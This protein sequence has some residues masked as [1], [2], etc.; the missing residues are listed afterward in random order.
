MIL[1]AVMCVWN[2]E[3]IIESTVRHCFAQGCSQV[4]IIDNASTD[5]TVE[6]AVNAGA[7]LA[8][9][10]KTKY[11]DEDKKVAH[12]N[13]TVEY[14]NSITSD[15][16][17]WWLYLDADEF[18]NFDSKFTI[19]EVLKNLDSSVRA[20]HGAMFDHKPTH[21]PYYVSGY[22]P[23]DFQP[24]CTKSSVGKIPL[25]RYDRG[26]PHLFSM[27]GA[28]NFITQ[29]DN[30]LVANDFIQ[31]H[32]F[33]YRNPEATLK[34]STKLVHRN[35]DGSSRIDWHDNF[36]KEVH[37]AANSK[38]ALSQYMSRHNNLK[39][40]YTANKH[41]IL[42]QNSLI[43][44]YKY[45][46]R[47]YNIDTNKMFNISYYDESVHL[48]IYHYF[49]HQYNIALCRFKDAFDVCENYNI[50]LLLL[51]KIA[52]C[53]AESEIETANSIVNNV[54]KYNNN[55]V[56]NYINNNLGY[57]INKINKEII[58]KKCNID[59]DTYWHNK[60]FPHDIAEMY[61]KLPKLSPD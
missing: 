27:G 39:K 34:R 53:F 8:T 20:V 11:F 3:D 54:I 42:K 16:N 56:N 1:N 58:N 33:P 43:Y 60:D 35:E 38:P 47:H 57:I 30:I 48:A 12:L 13:A 6:V 51:V 4:F 36:L 17:V 46:K 23:A 28:H 50:K 24:I 19:L 10:F 44:D 32:H 18:P 26:R 41:T 59:I 61:R 2:E 25:L 31:I 5:K 45:I 22:H 9:T 29:G 52:E 21:K 37:I 15:D 14:I 55:E 40:I 7:K 49:L